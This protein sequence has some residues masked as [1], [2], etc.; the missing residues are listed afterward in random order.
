MK[1]IAWTLFLYS[2]SLLVYA[3]IA[4]SLSPLMMT[5]GIP[6]IQQKQH[7]IVKDTKLTIDTQYPLFV[8]DKLSTITQHYNDVMNDIIETEVGQFRAL[9]D[10]TIQK[11]D[12]SIENRGSSIDIQYEI[13][14]L[15]PEEKPLLSIRFTILKNLAGAAHP[16]ITH[17]TLNFDFSRGDALGIAELFT[18]NVDFIPILNAY[19]AKQ[20]TKVTGKTQKEM[21]DASELS[22]AQWNIAPT[23]LLI[24]F[25]EFAQ[26]YG[27]L[28]VLIPYSSLKKVL[29]P[30]SIVQQCITDVN[31]CKK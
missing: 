1:K 10:E 23:G 5:D 16:N 19:A 25:D 7:Q 28:E 6:L 20:L 9:V 14:M 18:P 12:T 30:Y 11:M 2:I 4:S 17:R 22:Y 15:T 8:S 21:Q 26:V 3:N 29:L 31:N 13:I 24:S 27:P